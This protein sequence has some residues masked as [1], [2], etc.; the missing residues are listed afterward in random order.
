MHACM[1]LRVHH[2]SKSY[3]LQKSFCNSKN[4][5]IVYQYCTHSLCSDQNLTEAHHDLCFRRKKQHYIKNPID[6]TTETRGYS[7]KP[8]SSQ[9]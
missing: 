3:I 6:Q 1:L 8:P 9:S 7:K 2:N 4:L 5:T